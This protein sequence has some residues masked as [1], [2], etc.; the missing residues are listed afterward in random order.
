MTPATGGAHHLP[1]T[2]VTD[3]QPANTLNNVLSTVITVVTFVVLLLLGTAVGLLSTSSAGWLTRYW[4][5]GQ[6]APALAVT[7]LVLYLVLLYLLC[8]L[9]AWGSRR[10]SGAIAFAVGFLGAILA[11]TSY[12]PG[13]DILLTDHLVHYAFMLGSMVVL[14]FAVVR[15]SDHLRPRVAVGGPTG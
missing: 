13:G 1:S 7:G 4:D 11:V 15:S 6:P 3:A 9:L 2:D 10:Q 5:G 12:L 8:R 14:A